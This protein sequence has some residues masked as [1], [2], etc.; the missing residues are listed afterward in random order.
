MDQEDQQAI[1]AFSIK[2]HVILEEASP[3]NIQYWLH[4][5]QLLQRPDCMVLKNE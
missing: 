4:K 1:E 5:I 2:T 3:S